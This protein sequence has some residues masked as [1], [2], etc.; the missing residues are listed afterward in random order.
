[1]SNIRNN[2]VVIALVIAVTGMCLLAAAVSAAEA[3]AATKHHKTVII[4]CELE[5]DGNA[6]HCNS[7]VI[8]SHPSPSEHGEATVERRMLVMTCELIH[9]SAQHCTAFAQVQPAPV[10]IVTN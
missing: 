3:G 10:Q 1:M 8:G 6:N 2:P 4:Q 5:R 7:F 9:G